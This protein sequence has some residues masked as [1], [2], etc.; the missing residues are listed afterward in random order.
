M[1]SNIVICFRWSFVT[2]H[3]FDFM[4]TMHWLKTNCQVD[5]SNVWNFNVWKHNL[6]EHIK[7]VESCYVL[8]RCGIKWTVHLLSAPHGWDPT[9]PSPPW[10]GPFSFAKTNA[11]SV[12]TSSETSLVAWLLKSPSLMIKTNSLMT[13]PHKHH[14]GCLNHHFWWNYQC[15]WFFGRTI[16][17]N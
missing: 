6:F 11:W 8:T 12:H 10:H 14:S 16:F 5:G 15:S 2:I 3:V 7:R 4:K 17:G 9:V 1:R 13:K